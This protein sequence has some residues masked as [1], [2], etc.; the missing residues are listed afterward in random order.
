MKRGTRAAG[1]RITLPV[2]GLRPSRATR[3]LTMKVPKPPMVTRRPFLRASKTLA[4]KA[5]NARSADTL[6]PPEAL[7]MAVTRSALVMTFSFYSMA[8]R[9]VKMLS[10]SM[11]AKRLSAVNGFSSTGACTSSTNCHGDGLAVSPVMN[12]KRLASPG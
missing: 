8:V 5:L 7:A 10:C 2:R 4:T 6:L 11:A 1:I 3:L 9:A 12:T